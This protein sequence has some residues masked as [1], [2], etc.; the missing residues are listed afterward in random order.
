MKNPSD[1]DHTIAQFCEALK[2]TQ[3]VLLTCHVLPEG[4][5]AGSI[6][7]MDS[8][9]KRLGKKT[10][11]IAQDI[12]PK[13]IAFMAESRWK[14]VDQAPSP[15]PKWDALVVA[16]CATL[17]RIGRVRGLIQPG[18]KIF[19]IDHHVTNTRF[20]DLNYIEPQA[21]SS[22][23]VVYRVFQ[24]FKMP[25]TKKEAE[26]IYV[27]LVTDT[28]SFRYSNTG[29]PTHQLAAELIRYGIDTE[30]IHEEIHS[31][32]TLNKMYLYSHLFKNVATA[33]N[34]Q[35]AWATLKRKD[36]VRY[37][38]DYEDT[39]GFVDF[40]KYLQPVKIAFFASEL[41]DQNAIRVSFRSRGHYDVNKIAGYFQGGGHKK[42]SGCLF[43]GITLKEAVVRVLERIQKDI[44][45]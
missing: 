41:P 6:L 19:N 36:L 20:G 42:S 11:V 44:H 7:A 1:K 15:R 17:E 29:A 28:G 12:Y 16:D 24:H 34:E 35:I 30:K 9:L 4:D 25:L 18:T 31:N 3:N 39:E 8:L 13:N 43:Q 33:C 27:A 10:W 32:F 2:K 37:G 14:M 21:S 40:L 45:S 38:A 5:A 22:G 23:E 26:F